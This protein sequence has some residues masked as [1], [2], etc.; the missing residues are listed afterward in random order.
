MHLYTPQFSRELDQPAV[1]LRRSVLIASTPRCGSHMLGHAMAGT[2]LLGVPFEYLNPANLAEWSR[3]L[4]TPGAEATLGELMARRT[5]AN[6][7]FA[8]KA[9]FNQCAEVGGAERL[10]RLL[11]DLRVIHIRRADILRQ[12]ISY[13]VARQTG[14]WITGQE[15]MSGEVL[16]DADQV[17]AC[18]RDIAIQNARWTSA[19]SA[20]GIEPLS[21][22]Y[23]DVAQDLSA[24][25]TRVAAHADVVPNGTRLDV[26]I[27]TKRQSLDERT[28]DWISNYAA[29][30]GQAPSPVRRLRDRMLKVTT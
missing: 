2:N 14:V 29:A 30:R 23:E 28:E 25:V 9:H 6:G 8:I 4:W 21:L 15:E 7:V 27:K 19:F 3:R 17:D 16:F 11:P 13:A 12:A 22:V 24:A 26:S 18:L 20:A 10:F 1:A 5:T